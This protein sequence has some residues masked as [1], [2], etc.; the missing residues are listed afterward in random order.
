MKPA[1]NKTA[2][3]FLSLFPPQPLPWLNCAFISIN[4]EADYNIFPEAHF[5]LHGTV[6][7]IR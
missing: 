5:E 6:Y 7:R 3:H 2:K 1:L 4:T